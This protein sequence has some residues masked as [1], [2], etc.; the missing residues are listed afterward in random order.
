MSRDAMALSDETGR[1]LS[2]NAAY[3]EHFGD[4][5]PDG[6]TPAMVPDGGLPRSERQFGAGWFAVQARRT[7]EGVA[8]L[9]ESLAAE[10]E[11]A[12]AAHLRELLL[13]PHSR[14]ECWSGRQCRQSP[15]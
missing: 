15:K 9:F 2:C 8:W 11:A 6:L 12:E 4:R 13:R 3:R 7:A 5:L 1:L 14:P 10:R